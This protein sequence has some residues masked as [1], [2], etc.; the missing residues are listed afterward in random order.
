M[1]RM[2]EYFTNQRAEFVKN[3]RGKMGLPKRETTE[4]FGLIYK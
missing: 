1:K 3:S 2:C 4:A